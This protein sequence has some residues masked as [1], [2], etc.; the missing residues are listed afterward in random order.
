MQK[1]EVC[2]LIT[3]KCNERCHYCHR[4]LNIQDVS[5]DDNKKILMNL[6]QEDIK[7]I[8][9]SGGEALLYPHILDLMKIAKENNIENKL[10]TNGEIL[11]KDEKMRDVFKYIDKITLSIDSVNNE[12]NEVLGRG[13]NHFE[14]VKEVLDYI[15]ENSI[16]T[17]VTINTV[18]SK[19]NLNEVQS[20]GEFLNNYNITAL[21]VFK[22]I[23]L[24]EAAVRNREQFDISNTDFETEKNKFFEFNNI[25]KIEFRNEQDME[26]KYILLVP[27]GDIVRTE[28]GKDVVKGNALT[29]NLSKFGAKVKDPYRKVKVYIATKQKEILDNIE[30]KVNEFKWAEIDGVS[31]NGNSAI[32]DI[33]NKKPEIVF[34]EYNLA[35]KNG[36]DVI[37]ETCNDEAIK[38]D[39]PRFNI[40]EETPNC[41]SNEEIKDAIKASKGRISAKITPE[42]IKTDYIINLMNDFAKTEKL[43]Y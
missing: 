4:F 40:I 10:I 26:N 20:L 6:I 32:S 2:W 12:V 11:A 34:V 37:K 36:I 5:F 13:Y 1:E 3:T 43:Q 24:R 22:F 33:I 8:T 14:N 31:N 39:C 30:N 35:D 21:R 38:Y 28:N 17:E 19:K 27:N 29:D 15:K 7:R 23:P 25:K 41:I 16:K 18:V 9:W 42:L